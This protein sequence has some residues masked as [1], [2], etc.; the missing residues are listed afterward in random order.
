MQ[1]RLVSELRLAKAKTEQET[2][3]ALERFVEE[4]NRKFKKTPKSEELAYRKLDPDL[5]LNYIL[6][7]RYERTVGNDHCISLFGL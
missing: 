5:D 4:Y 2:N 3:A 1:D 6:S 7:L